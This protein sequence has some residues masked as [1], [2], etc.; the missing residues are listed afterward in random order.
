MKK[1]QTIIICA[2]IITT[3]ACKNNKN[4]AVKNNSDNQ[5]TQ[6]TSGTTNS[7]QTTPVSVEANKSQGDTVPAFYRVVVSLYSIGEGI[8]PDG[9]PILDN[10]SQQFMDA[11]SKRIVYDSHPWGREGETD[12]C[13][14]LDNLSSEEQVRFINGLTEAFKGHELVRIIENKKNT[15]RQ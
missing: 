10:Y 12:F 11:S 14:T 3:I 6:S 7:S 15:Y 5:T 8:D 9:R 13:Y 2:I 4:A 1:V